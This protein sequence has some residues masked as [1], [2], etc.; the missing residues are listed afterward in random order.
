M[1]ESVLIALP[2]GIVLVIAGVIIILMFVITAGP[3]TP[4][5]GALFS[6]LIGRDVFGQEEYVVCIFSVCGFGCVTLGMIKIIF[7]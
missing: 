6:K 1:F 5:Y 2:Q 4:S 3:E 7:Y